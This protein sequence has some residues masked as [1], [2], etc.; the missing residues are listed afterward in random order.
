MEKFCFF[1]FYSIL[2]QTHSLKTISG[3]MNVNYAKSYLLVRQPPATLY[4]INSHST[5]LEIIYECPPS[6]E[7]SAECGSNK[8]KVFVQRLFQSNF[9][10]SFY[11]S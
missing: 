8:K 4:H 11:I 9:G 10:G 1:F 3:I 6:N 7:K 5:K 2:V